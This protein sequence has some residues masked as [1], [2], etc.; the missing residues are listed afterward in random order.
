MIF[1]Y[2]IKIENLFINID[3]R[4]LMCY[5]YP[6]SGMVKIRREGERRKE[7]TGIDGR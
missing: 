3:I 2:N 1:L 6:E 5:H 7:A 4:I